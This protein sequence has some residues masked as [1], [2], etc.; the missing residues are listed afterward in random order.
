[1]VCSEGP[2]RAGWAIVTFGARAKLHSRR[3]EVLRGGIY[4]VG[5]AALHGLCCG[6]RRLPDTG[7]P[8]ALIVWCSQAHANATIVVGGTLASFRRSSSH[9]CGPTLSCYAIVACVTISGNSNLVERVAVLAARAGLALAFFVEIHMSTESAY[10]ASDCIRDRN[11][12]F[13][14]VPALRTRSWLAHCIIWTIKCLRTWNAR[15]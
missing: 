11:C 12:A 15:A 9:R 2:R 3:A 4:R 7:V 8:Q 10:R 14:A 1:M 6:G 13:G 5:V